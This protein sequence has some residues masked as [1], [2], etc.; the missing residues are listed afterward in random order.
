MC[1]NGFELFRANGTAGF[2]V[3][4]PENGE[5]D[6]DVYQRNKTCVPVM[7]PQLKS[8]ENGLLLSTKDQ[9]HFGNLASF[10]CNFGYVL[11]GASNLLCTSGG[12]WNGTEPECQCK[13]ILNNFHSMDWVLN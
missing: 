5:R 4:I 12:I 9:Y 1:N 7:C 6:G 10:Q 11:V 13:W 2:T 3:A 8:P